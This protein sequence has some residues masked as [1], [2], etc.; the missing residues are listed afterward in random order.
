MCALMHHAA[1]SL[2]VPSSVVNTARAPRLRAAGQ[3]TLDQVLYATAQIPPAATASAAWLL[4]RS[5]LL[6]SPNP[7]EH[8]TKLPR[9]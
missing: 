1:P 5:Q 8:P 6:L 2:S 4:Q 3:T 7:Q 9:R